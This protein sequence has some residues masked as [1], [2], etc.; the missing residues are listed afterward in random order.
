L[1]APFVAANECESAQ[2]SQDQFAIING[3][4]SCYVC[5]RPF[6]DNPPVKIYS[7]NISSD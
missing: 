5:L 7:F 6:A 2:L 1:A 3:S 4:S